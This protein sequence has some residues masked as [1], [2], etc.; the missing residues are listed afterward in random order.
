M[1]ITNVSKV[2]DGEPIPLKNSA[3]D[4]STIYVDNIASVN[5]DNS[6]AKVG[7]IEVLPGPDGKAAGRF[8][9]NIAMGRANIKALLD[10]LSSALA[11]VEQAE[12]PDNVH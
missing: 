11:A 12:Q 7:F 1:A 2:T 9:V 3:L 6:V 5:I 10:N 8:V 4:V